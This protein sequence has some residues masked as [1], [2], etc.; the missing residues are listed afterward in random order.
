MQNPLKNEGSAMKTRNKYF[1]QNFYFI[2]THLL[3]LV[4][5]HTVLS[6]VYESVCTNVIYSDTYL[7]GI[8][9]IA[10]DVVALVIWAH[11]FSVLI[12]SF[13]FNRGEN[14]VF[15]L[16]SAL[17][18]FF[19]RYF[20]L[21]IGVTANGVAINGTEFSYYVT[22]SLISFSLDAAQFISA[23][24]ITSFIVKKK[25]EKSAKKAAFFSALIIAIVRVGMRIRYD[26]F[27]GLPESLT[28]LM[29]MVVYYTSDILYA[30]VIFLIIL[31]AVRIKKNKLKEA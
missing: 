26:F 8:I 22:D 31:F 3:L 25:K 29:W 1:A 28:D 4:L 23:Y 11:L 24:L 6:N 5:Y 9:E 7:P 21:L 30:A 15:I 10:F 13:E 17:I 16:V 27:Y 19:I 18:M 12:F 14:S 20:A 2:L